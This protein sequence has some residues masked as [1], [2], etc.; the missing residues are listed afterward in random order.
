MGDGSGVN[1]GSG[2]FVGTSV[3]VGKGVRVGGITV[4]VGMDAGVQPLNNT[5]STTN[6]K[7]ID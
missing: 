4:G 2:V 3:S 7:N 6:A 1:V 5:V